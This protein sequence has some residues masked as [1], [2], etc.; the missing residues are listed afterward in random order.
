MPC[1]RA[2]PTIWPLPLPILA[3]AFVQ[4]TLCRMVC[5]RKG[6]LLRYETTASLNGLPL[7][8]L[9]RIGYFRRSWGEDNITAGFGKTPA[10]A[11]LFYRGCALTIRK[12]YLSHAVVD[13][14]FLRFVRVGFLITVCFQIFETCKGGLAAS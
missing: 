6:L 1:R 3:A 5:N 11:V 4:T 2:K 8:L 14:Y 9:I 7:W 13:L 12:L 10:E